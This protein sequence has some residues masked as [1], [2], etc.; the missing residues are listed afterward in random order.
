MHQTLDMKPMLF[1]RY[2]FF[3]FTIKA[4]NTENDLL[5]DK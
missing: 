3:S 5:I 4:V 1:H 2:A